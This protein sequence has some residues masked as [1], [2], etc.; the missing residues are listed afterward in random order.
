MSI[1]ITVAEVKSKA[2]IDASE[3]SHDLAI[4][5]L[6]SQMQPALEYSVADR[7]LQDTSNTG[8]QAVIK[9]GVLEI[10]TGEFLEQLRR[11]LGASE[12]FSIAGLS[13]GAAP[14]CGVDLIQQGA[15]RLEPYLKSALPMMGDSA[16]RCS[17]TDIDP[18][19][20]VDE[21]VW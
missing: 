2:A 12:E 13:I 17:T 18:V 5:A 16:C 21:E 4:A 3:T 11:R 19:F 9:L 10:I 6:I 7:Y 8:L 20:S 14:Q 15:V 1:T